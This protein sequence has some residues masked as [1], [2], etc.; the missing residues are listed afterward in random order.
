MRY[1]SSATHFSDCAN[2][3]YASDELT[4]LTGFQFKKKVAEITNTIHTQVDAELTTLGRDIQF[5]VK[6]GFTEKD[7]RI[8]ALESKYTEMDQKNKELILSLEKEKQLRESYNKALHDIYD[9]C[10]DIVGEK[11]KRSDD[12]Q[13]QGEKES[14][15]VSL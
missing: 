15:K 1:E 4:M 12:I 10:V 5:H 7:T 8:Q 14:K 13:D 11:R 3:K 6:K 2:T 9:K